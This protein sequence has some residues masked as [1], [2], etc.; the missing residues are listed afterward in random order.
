MVVHFK[1]QLIQTMVVLLRKFG[2]KELSEEDTKIKQSLNVN[3]KQQQGF[4]NYLSKKYAPP[5]SANP[6]LINLV[7]KA[8]E[9]TLTITVHLFKHDALMMDFLISCKHRQNKKTLSPEF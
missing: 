6:S 5:F 9:L 2:T 3:A 4:N 7:D 8:F 1:K